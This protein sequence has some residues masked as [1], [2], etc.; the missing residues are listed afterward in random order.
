MVA[1]QQVGKIATRVRLRNIGSELRRL[2]WVPIVILGAFLFM[3]AFPG[4]FT[5]YDPYKMTLTSRLQPPGWEE[6]GRQYL[7]GTDTL[8]RDLLTRI[9][10]GARIS[11]IVAGAGLLF[12]TGL[13]V[14]LFQ[15]MW[16]HG[17]GA[18]EAYGLLYGSPALLIALVFVIL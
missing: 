14:A 12:E 16:S 2:P 15:A 13:I 1:E 3:A 11:L 6:G 8:G 18:H 5:P 9:F 17:C 10:Y 4:W 7:L